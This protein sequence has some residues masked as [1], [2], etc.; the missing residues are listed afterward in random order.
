[1]YSRSMKD[2]RCARQLKQKIHHYREDGFRAGKT[3]A[4]LFGEFVQADVLP[5]CHAIPRE[6]YWSS[7]YIR[8]GA[9]IS[10]KRSRARS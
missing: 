6:S 2:S 7:G 10:K 5:E 8:S 4:Q 3:E 1:M 9:T